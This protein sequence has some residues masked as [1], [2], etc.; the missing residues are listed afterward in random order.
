MQTDTAHELYPHERMSRLI[1][2]LYCGLENCFTLNTIIF[3]QNLH[4]YTATVD[5][6]EH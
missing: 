2:I 3:L 4:R 1:A 5:I 6:T